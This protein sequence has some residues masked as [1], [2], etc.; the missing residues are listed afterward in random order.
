MT[1][2]PDTLS[3]L[4]RRLARVFVAGLTASAAALVLGLLLYFIAQDSKQTSVLLGAGLIALMATPL[5]RVIVSISQYL[6]MRD[7]VFAALTCAVLA[8]LMVTLIYALQQR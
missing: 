6:R 3:D 1:G 2:A 4:E 7:W 8:E 5:L